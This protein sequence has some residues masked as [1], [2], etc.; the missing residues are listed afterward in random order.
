[1]DK[2]NS[3]LNQYGVFKCNFNHSFKLGGSH[4]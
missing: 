2:L 1:M 4:E 3:Y